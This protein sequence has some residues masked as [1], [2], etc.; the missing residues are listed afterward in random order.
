[1]IGR[2]WS[3][4]I[5]AIGKQESTLGPLTETV[6]AAHPELSMSV[7][8]DLWPEESFYTR[9]DH[10][11][12]ARNGVPILFFFNGVHDDY[13]QVTDE[14]DKIDYDK[15]AR[16]GRLIFYLGLEVADA[17]ERPIWDADAY[18]RIVEVPAEGGEE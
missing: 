5:V 14:I 4:T 3:D 17:D 2:N 16:I 12:F 7:I 6:A 10:F 13:H 9:S 1:M 18:A 8:D 15:M 11:N